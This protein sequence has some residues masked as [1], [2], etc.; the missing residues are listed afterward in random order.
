MLAA[1]EDGASAEWGH[2][3]IYSTA[4]KALN[5]LAWAVG[6]VERLRG[7]MLWVRD[8]D[9]FPTYLDAGFRE[10]YAEFDAACGYVPK[11]HGDEA[12]CCPKCDQEDPNE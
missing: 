5:L 9:A 7:L 1:T 12:C 11:C 4:G 8:E 2:A 10:K 3:R 6:E